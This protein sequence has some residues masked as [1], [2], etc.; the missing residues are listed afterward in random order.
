MKD[1]VTF[2]SSKPMESYQVATDQRFL[3]NSL[4]LL[5]LHDIDHS[6][7]VLGRIKVVVTSP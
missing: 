3:L 5:G 1:C 6:T 2:T 7:T 4:S